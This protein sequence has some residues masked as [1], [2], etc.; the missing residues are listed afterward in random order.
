MRGKSQ[1]FLR[2]G[3]IASDE[4]L[5]NPA[6]CGLGE[7]VPAYALRA[8]G[9]LRTPQARRARGAKNQVWAKVV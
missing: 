9:V 8:P 5:P 4:R 3:E 2:V 6:W 1:P 7:A